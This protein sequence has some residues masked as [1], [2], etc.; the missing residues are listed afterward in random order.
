MDK[1]TV[2]YETLC[3][4]TLELAGRLITENGG[5]IFRVEETIT[6]M[7]HGL[8]LDRVECFATPTGLFISMSQ[9]NRPVRTSVFRLRTGDTDLDKVNR[10]NQISRDVESGVLDLEAAHKALL[11]IKNTPSRIPAW[12]TCLGSGLTAC[13]FSVLFGG[14][15]PEMGVAFIIGV[16]TWVLLLQV[17]KLGVSRTA[18]T[19]LVSTLITLS[20]T[21]LCKLTG[22]FDQNALIPGSLM[23][24]VPG[25]AMTGAVQDTMRGDTLSGLSSGMRAILTAVLIAAGAILGVRLAGMIL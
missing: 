7:G 11:E 21:V 5:E 4:E 15:L 9:D 8:K 2:E 14:K 10:V 19:L 1:K 12:V 24:L 16:L 3:M 6:R 18:P 22:V 23:P 13:G 20:L 25:L 17:P